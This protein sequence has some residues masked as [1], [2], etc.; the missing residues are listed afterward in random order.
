MRPRGFFIVL[1]IM[2]LVATG[3]GAFADDCSPNAPY[4]SVCNNMIKRPSELPRSGGSPGQPQPGGG[5]GGNRAANAA[6]AMNIIGNMIGILDELRAAQVN[7]LVRLSAEHNSQGIWL[8]NQG[9]DEE[10]AEQFALAAD[11]ARE[12]GDEENY[13]INYRNGVAAVMRAA[14]ARRQAQAQEQRRLAAAAR[15]EDDRKRQNF[16]DPFGVDP[17]CINCYGSTGGRAN[18]PPAKAKGP[19]IQPSKPQP[20]NSAEIEDQIAAIKQAIADMPEGERRDK[21]TKLLQDIENGK[22]D[23][24]G[25]KPDGGSPPTPVPKAETPPAPAPEAVPPEPSPSPPEKQPAV[26]LSPEI[27]QALADKPAPGTYRHYSADECRRL[28]GKWSDNGAWSTC[29]IEP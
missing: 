6:A 14:E 17:I 1:G 22:T 29:V 18:P 19:T 12:A 21:F 2:G 9:R 7:H 5:G 10:A 26:K 20:A 25:G 3:G 28:Q 4:G 24:L 27:E 8:A 11:Y 13:E 16:T 15:A 23:G